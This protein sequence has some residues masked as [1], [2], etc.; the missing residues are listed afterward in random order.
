MRFK[1]IPTKCISFKILLERSILAIPLINL[2]KDC[3]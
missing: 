3:F 1:F 2:P